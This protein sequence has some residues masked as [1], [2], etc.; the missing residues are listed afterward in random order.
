[1]TSISTAPSE[2]RAVG[3]ALSA[4]L[5]VAMLGF[6]QVMAPGPAQADEFDLAGYSL[7]WDAAYKRGGFEAYYG[8]RK[9]RAGLYFARN[10][11]ILAFDDHFYKTSRQG[12]IIGKSGG[13][14]VTNLFLRGETHEVER[15]GNL[16]R[17]TMRQ[18]SAL[19]G[20]FVTT[21]I[22]DVDS[23]TQCRVR[24]FKIEGSRMKNAK[25]R[26]GA[27]RIAPGKQDF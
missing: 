1:M 7:I 18:K 9:T 8:F 23:P 6:M 26:T 10:G 15:R 27:C 16:L 22:I 14:G 12:T 2:G 11:N 17:L 19:T 21:Y 3:R 5:V 20:T 25:F 24:A 4:T 13:K